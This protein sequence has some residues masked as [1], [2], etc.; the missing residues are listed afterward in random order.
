MSYTASIMILTAISIER[1]FA[2]IH[3]MRSKQLTTLCLLRIVVVIVWT[4][5]AG[6]A[7]PYLILYDTIRIQD[8]E[9]CIQM[10]HFDSKSYVTI[11]FIL[12]Y[13]IPLCLMTVMYT[14]ISIVLWKTSNLENL[15]K[16]SSFKGKKSR[17]KRKKKDLRGIRLKALGKRN[18]DQDFGLCKP[19]ISVSGVATSTSSDETTKDEGRR[20]TYVPNTSMGHYDQRLSKG[21]AS[22]YETTDKSGEEEDIE[23]RSSEEAADFEDDWP[24]SHKNRKD[25]IHM[26]Q[27][28]T[29]R[30]PTY[31]GSCPA[32]QNGTSVSGSR[33]PQEKCCCA[34]SPLHTPPAGGSTRVGTGSCTRGVQNRKPPRRTETALLARRRVIRLLIAVIVSFAI[35]VIPYHIRLLVFIW[36]EPSLSFAESLIPPLT[37]LIFYFNSGLNPI[38][39][40]F[41]SD[42]FRRSLREVLCCTADESTRRRSM[43]STMSVKTLHSTI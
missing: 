25:D 22:G 11:S 37:F 13:L 20:V 40:A 1:Y 7:V 31:N 28:Y 5:A 24:S 33:V 38:L 16:N 6:C 8:D 17:T 39:Y 27:V 26:K 42:N 30:N 41:L 36:R 21:V 32:C 12:W 14:K 4:I 18:P 10:G 19:V 29:F 9:Y 43:R 3:P 23:E 34:R 2:I 15:E 35:C